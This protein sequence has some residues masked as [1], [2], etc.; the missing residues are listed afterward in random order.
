MQWEKLLQQTGCKWYCQYASKRPT[1]K[2]AYSPFFKREGGN[3]RA[4][5]GKLHCRYCCCLLVGRTGL[6]PRQF[7]EISF[8]G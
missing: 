5:H 2:L 3:V 8:Q 1:S 7:S 6:V 4:M